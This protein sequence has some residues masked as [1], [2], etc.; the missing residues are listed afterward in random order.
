MP[1]GAASVRRFVGIAGAEQHLP[2]QQKRDRGMRT[3]EVRVLLEGPLEPC[4]CLVIGLGS[5]QRE[6][7]LTAQPAIIGQQLFRGRAQS[8]LVSGL[9]GAP[10]Q[11]GDDRA[12]HIVLNREHFIQP[13]IVVL[14][15]QLASA[16][17]VEQLH[18]NAQPV[19]QP[20]HAAFDDIV[21]TK[22]HAYLSAAGPSLIGEGGG[23]AD[24]R[25]LMEPA[26]LGDEV[27]RDSV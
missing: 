25:E 7:M 9:N 12:R 20:A 1:Q 24:H 11:L 19:A 2:V 17:G 18:G 23:R 22:F 16:L 21:S 27:R 26:K 8:G 6:L 3:G 4:Q 10:N 15:H 5:P 13:A 14:G